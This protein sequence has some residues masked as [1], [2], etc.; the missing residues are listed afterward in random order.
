MAATVSFGR[1]YAS[2][3]C[4]IFHLYMESKAFIKSTNN[5]VAC[6]FFARTSS[7]ILRIVNIDIYIYIYIYIFIYFGQEY[8]FTLCLFRWL[9]MLNLKVNIYIYI[10]I[11]ICIYIYI[12]SQ[13]KHVMSSEETKGKMIFLTEINSQWQ[14]N[15]VWVFF[16]FHYIY[17]YIIIIIMS[18]R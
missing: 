4:S 15:Q 11:Y 17:I 16:P 3:I 7:R 1:L 8:H 5:I 14:F 6:R 18:C 10:Y 2:R 12:H 13:I 9:Y